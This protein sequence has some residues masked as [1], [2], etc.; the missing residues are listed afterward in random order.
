LIGTGAGV[1]L[2][3]VEAIGGMN[4]DPRVVSGMISVAVEYPERL[5]ALHRCERQTVN[6]RPRDFRKPSPQLLEHGTHRSCGSIGS[7]GD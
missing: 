2:S 6:P 4:H 7:G 5:P 1:A 3:R